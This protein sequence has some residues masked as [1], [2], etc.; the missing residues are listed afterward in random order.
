MFLDDI[1]HVW[2]RHNYSWSY[3]I[4]DYL[5]L[6]I[7]CLYKKVKSY[8]HGIIS[9]GIISKHYIELI[10]NKIREKTQMNQWWIT[11]SVIEWFK[12]IKNKS[13]RSFI[14]FDIVEFYH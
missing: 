6:P 5:Y 11:K 1:V 13:K 10:N 14:K 7:H 12:A 2:H 9:I 3:Q 8:G 4:Q